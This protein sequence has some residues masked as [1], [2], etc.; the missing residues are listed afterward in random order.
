[1]L[2]VEKLNIFQS[3]HLSKCKWSPVASKLSQHTSVRVGTHLPFH[4]H[5]AAASILQHTD[6]G[7]QSRGQHHSPCVRPIA[8]ATKA[9]NCTSLLTP[10]GWKAEL[11]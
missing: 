6:S 8:S 10:E 4:G 1:M 11:A 2:S 9:P 7:A 5:W 3:K